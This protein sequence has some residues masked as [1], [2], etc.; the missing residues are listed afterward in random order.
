MAHRLRTLQKCCLGLLLWSEVPLSL[1][2][3]QLPFDFEWQPTSFYRWKEAFAGGRRTIS[4]PFQ[5]LVMNKLPCLTSLS[6]PLSS[7]PHLERG[8][9]C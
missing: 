5:N 4:D 8:V 3:Y 6:P 2:R 1:Y 9:K 7:L